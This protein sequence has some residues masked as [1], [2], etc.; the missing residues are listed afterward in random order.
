MILNTTS[1]LELW[2]YL[3]SFEKTLEK[4]SWAHTLK[5]GLLFVSPGKQKQDICKTFP[6]AAAAAALT[7]VEFLHLSHFLRDYKG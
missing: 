4:R 6:A 1:Y 2:Q 3:F 7:F 5:T